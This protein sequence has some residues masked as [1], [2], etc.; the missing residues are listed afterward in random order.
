ME[1]TGKIRLGSPLT[2]NDWLIH[3]YEEIEMGPEGVHYMLDSCKASGW[4][5]IYWR[6]RDGGRAYY[7]SAVSDTHQKRDKDSYNTPQTPKDQ[8]LVDYFEKS[9]NIADDEEKRK[10]LAKLESLDYAQFDSLE[11]AVRYGHEIG[12][13][14]HAWISINEEDHAW[15][16]S[17]RYVK[18]TRN[19]VG[20]DE[21]VHSTIPS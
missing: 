1:A 10:S 17:S 20:R 3:K 6:T 2:H 14:V 8:K 7:K 4:T 16:I 5:R 18:L 9:M 21:M 11:E 13:E 15:G 19:S 12:I